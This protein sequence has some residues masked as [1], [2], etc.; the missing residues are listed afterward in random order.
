MSFKL[1]PSPTF[2]AT[3]PVRLP[4]GELADLQLEFRHR[5]RTAM[6]ALFDTAAGRTDEDVIA[7]VVAGWRDVDEA[8]SPEAV[9]TLVDNYPG[10]AGQIVEAYVRELVQA[11]RGN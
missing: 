6:A 10:V 5:S 7:D 2:W 11:R 3:V 9:R 4:G 1:Q 8:F